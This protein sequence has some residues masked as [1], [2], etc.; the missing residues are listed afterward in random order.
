[1]QQITR[2]GHPVGSPPASVSMR[3]VDHPSASPATVAVSL[4]ANAALYVDKGWPT[5]AFPD[6]RTRTCPNCDH[7]KHEPG[8]CQVECDDDASFR[9]GCGMERPL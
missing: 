5:A 7:L 8:A 6:H 2:K 4:T 1:M 9:C 3:S